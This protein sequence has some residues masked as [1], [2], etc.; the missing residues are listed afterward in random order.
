MLCVR[1]Y[2][3]LYFD[4][5]S[6]F[7]VFFGVPST[8]CI[9]LSSVVRGGLQNFCGSVILLGSFGCVF[10]DIPSQ[11]AFIGG[12]FSWSSYQ[13]TIGPHHSFEALPLL[14]SVYLS[15]L[16][17]MVVGASFCLGCPALL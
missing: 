7:S 3:A 11:T 2:W 9:Y 10:V 4:I 16:I 1:L 17:F 15:D 12:Q 8:F 5:L 13:E 14:F 6:F